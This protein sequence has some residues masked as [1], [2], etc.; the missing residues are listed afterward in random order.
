LQQPFLFIIF[1]TAMQA[2]CIFLFAATVLAAH[3]LL[4][5][6]RAAAQTLL[7]TPQQSSTTASSAA[8]Q[9]TQERQI[10][11]NIEETLFVITAELE[12]QLNLFPEY[13]GLVEARL[14]QKVTQPQAARSAQVQDSSFVLEISQSLFGRSERTRLTLA[15]AQ[16]QDL[17]ARVSAA[18][19]TMPTQDPELSLSDW[20]KT[21]TALNTGLIG[22]GYGL[23]ADA[24]N[25]S[26]SRPA[27]SIGAA[28]LLTPLAFAGGTIWAT[29][30]PWF[31]LAS[32]PMLN[33]GVI[34]GFL[35]GASLSLMVAEP[36]NGVL[37]T[38][39]AVLSG[40]VGSVAESA[41]GMIAAKNAGLNFGETTLLTSCGASGFG[42]GVLGSALAGA[43]GS[44]FDGVRL[45]LGAS[46]AASAGGYV[47]G[48]ALRYGQHIA[49]GDGLVMTAPV[50]VATLLPF[51]VLLTNARNSTSED[52]RTTGWLTLATHVGG[53]ALGSALITNKDF[54]LEQ[55]RAINQL[56]GLGALPGL[57]L[58]VASQNSEIGNAA[59]LIAVL[60]SAIG[61]G[62][63]YTQQAAQA[64]RQAA[65]RNQRLDAPTLFPSRSGLT[66]ALHDEFALW[67]REAEDTP[68]T[69]WLTRA[70]ERTDVQFSP[71]GLVGVVSPAL[72]PAGMSLPLVQIRHT[73]DT[74]TTFQEQQ[75]SLVREAE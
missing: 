39:T 13:P 6:T 36:R 52:L 44:S 11:F 38:Q 30:Q 40:I 5:N 4:F 28:T 1:Y 59:P 64:Q 15:A 34:M 24:S 66:P 32:L 42:V 35:H 70:A 26:V 33:N 58:L 20:Q 21:F 50:Q 73:F 14:F 8:P 19:A 17:R 65:E 54:S 47:L 12:E 56:M 51:S 25:V 69:R 29:S 43:F 71:L 7:T 10:A 68:L 62:I 23:F 27:S 31:S 2:R 16:V 18:L 67:Q 46:L 63:G 48:N 61:F 49:N 3:A 22:L 55:G 45:G 53:Y 57:A 72:V 75:R 74:P 60:G 41:F 37:A 9:T